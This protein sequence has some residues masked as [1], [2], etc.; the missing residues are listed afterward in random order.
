MSDAESGSATQ[1]N[2][3]LTRAN[4]TGKV[5]QIVKPEKRSR[6]SGRRGKMSVLQRKHTDQLKT[7]G[8]IS[9]RAASRHGL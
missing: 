6:R 2:A 9:E 4:V 3:S 8:L 5:P 7:R 1:A